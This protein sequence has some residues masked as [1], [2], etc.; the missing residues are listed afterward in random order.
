[1]KS[2]TLFCLASTFVIQLCNL[3]WIVFEFL[4]RL[5]FFFLVTQT[6]K[7][8]FATEIDLNVSIFLQVTQEISDETRVFRLLGSD[9]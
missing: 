5:I 7:L 3:H 6:N 4:K 2:K 8:H 9:R 1:M